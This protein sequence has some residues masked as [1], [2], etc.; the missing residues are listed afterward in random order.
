MPEYWLSLTRIFLCFYDQPLNE[1]LSNRTESVQL[2]AALAI[3]EDI[4]ESS[5]EKLYQK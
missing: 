4:Q 1:S 2:K 3:K 5:P